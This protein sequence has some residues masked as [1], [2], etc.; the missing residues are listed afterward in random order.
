[1]RQVYALGSG[2]EAE[3]LAGE[4]YDPASDPK[5]HQRSPDWLERRKKADDAE[6]EADRN[7]G[8]CLS[9][10]YQFMKWVVDSMMKHGKIDTKWMRD[11]CRSSSYP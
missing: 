5:R 11:S 1:M 8:R 6:E 7:G 4:R 3:T 9:A 10:S 2:N